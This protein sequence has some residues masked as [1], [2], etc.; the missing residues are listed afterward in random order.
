[1]QLLHYRFNDPPLTFIF[2]LSSNAGNY[3]FG[4]QFL[5]RQ[6]NKQE[7]LYEALQK[8]KEGKMLS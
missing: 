8:L 6:D 7:A 2:N 1:M 3:C 4:I 5:M